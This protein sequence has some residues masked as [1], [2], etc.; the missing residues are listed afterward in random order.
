M[1][2]GIRRLML[3]TLA[4]VLGLLWLAIDPAFQG[5]PS[6]GQTTVVNWLSHSAVPLTETTDQFGSLEK[7]FAAAR[8]IALG[9]ATHGQHESFAIKRRLTMH[10]IRRHGIRLVAY[11]ASSSQMIQA[12]QYVLGKTDDW[13]LAMRGFGMLIWQIEENRQLLEDLRAWN[14][15][16]PAGQQ[17]QIIGFDAQDGTAALDRL[18]ELMPSPDL[19]TLARLRTMVTTAQEALTEFNRGKPSLWEGT[20]KEIDDIEQWL[21]KRGPA[22]GSQ[23]DEYRLRVQEYLW[24]LRMYSSRGGRDRAMADL[25]RQQLDT[26]GSPTRCVLW[27]HNGHVQRTPLAYLGTTD[28]AMGGHLAEEFGSDYFAIGFAF[29]QGEF[30]ANAQTN[31]G[32]WGFRR[33]QLSAAPVGSLEWTL[34]QTGHSVFLVNLREAPA[35]EPIRTWLAAPQGQRWFGGYGVPD[36]CDAL[37]RDAAKLLP[38]TPGKDYDGLIYIDHTRAAVPLDPS[39]VISDKHKR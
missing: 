7:V 34:G 25:L 35:E 4:T 28:L 15:Q 32:Q 23:Q 38:T 36:D 31:S 1:T 33:Y 5:N 11:E 26:A 22:S 39:R 30:Q 18:S 21:Q 17:V 14:L 37:T 13:Q 20:A 19:Q 16:A 3:R 2:P 27:A 29:G 24:S 12:N 8:I 6:L 10:L 9:E